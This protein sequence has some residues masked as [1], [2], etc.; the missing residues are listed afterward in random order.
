MKVS[1]RYLILDSSGI[2][3]MNVKQ[4]KSVQLHRTID[5]LAQSSA[6]MVSIN[7]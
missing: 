3:H 6:I 4:N 1:K 7:R 2:V 5:K